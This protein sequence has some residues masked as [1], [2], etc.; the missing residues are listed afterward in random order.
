MRPPGAAREGGL[1]DLNA[2]VK[3]D[4][5]DGSV[6]A[7]ERVLRFVGDCAV[8]SCLR[9]EHLCVTKL[10]LDNCGLIVCSHTPN[11]GVNA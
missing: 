4:G 1:F 9:D 2:D 10:G 11:V 6:Q 5:T 7:Q 3:C 8:L